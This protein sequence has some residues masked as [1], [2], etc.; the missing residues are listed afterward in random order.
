M[1]SQDY[2]H[3]VGD[4]AGLSHYTVGLPDFFGE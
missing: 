2:V 1:V 4:I 3:L